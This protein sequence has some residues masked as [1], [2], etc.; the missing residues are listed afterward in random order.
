MSRT[1]STPPVV[2]RF[3]E[4]S[5]A[6]SADFP[7]KSVNPTRRMLKHNDAFL[8]CNAHGD[9]VLG[10]ANEEGYY[11]DG[12]RF[13]SRFSLKID[14][15]IPLLLG[16]HVKDQ[17]DAL[18]VTLTNGAQGVVLQGNEVQISKSI[19]LLESSC[20][21]TIQCENFSG[22]NA[23]FQFAIDFDADYADIY[24]IRGMPR[25]S[26]GTMQQSN[27]TS[28]S[29]ELAYVGLD[30]ERR[31]T[32]I[33]FD[34]SPQSV[35]ASTSEYMIKLEARE[36]FTMHAV[37]TCGRS[38]REQCLTL[39]RVEAEERLSS[40]R[41]RQLSDSVTVHSSNGQFNE[42]FDRSLADV[43]MM[44]SDLP[45]GP[46]PYA[47]IPWFNTPF[48]RDGIV[49]SLECLWMRPALARGVL[50]YL[51]E[52]QAT[53]IIPEE[54]A[55]PGKILHEIRRGEMAALKEMPFG[56]YYGS[57]DATPL[58]VMLAGAYY[59]RTADLDFIRALW[60]AVRSAIAWMKTYGDTD[61]DGFIEYKR[62]APNGL[63]HQAWKDSDDAI[64]HADGSPAQGALAVCEVQ[65]Y[66]YGA[67]RAGAV[68]AERLGH[69]ADCEDLT[70]RAE[71]LYER[72]NQSFWSEELQTYGL[73]L[74]G[75]KKLC[76]VK[77][78]NAGQCLFS[79]VA[80]PSRA[81]AIANGLFAPDCYSGWG[82][83]TL[84][85]NSARFNP[86]SYHN[87]SV[88]PHDNGLI[89]LGLS[90]YGLTDYVCQL[91]EDIF[92]SVTYF[93]RYRL[94]ELFC[95]FEREKGVAPV[96]YPVACAPQ[97]WSA[98]S[99]FL[100]IQACLGLQIDGIS[101]EV[102]LTRP[103]LPGSLRDIQIHN[104]TV[105]GVVLNFEVSG[106]GS[107]TNIKT[108]GDLKGCSLRLR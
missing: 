43:N 4:D 5:S 93:D 18:V 68:L 29:V 22:G 14:D 61:G 56:R 82:I 11:F 62:Q 80:P 55:E 65:G 71:S 79:G 3:E 89:A 44:T 28:S 23:E 16:S 58:F 36:T 17:N 74:D 88:W 15:E 73:A 41:Q 49:T 101:R 54:D 30:Q 19:F 107:N 94:P 2:P 108:A 70:Q 45:T 92:A 6:P 38:G 7:M 34:P 106:S 25:V 104:L 77:S 47:G 59:E 97:S 86:M 102:S 8:L 12:T 51:A 103:M 48:G 85:S 99:I 100:L 40:D 105:G 20:Y 91:F 63:I 21:V 75:D 31:F 26:H 90:R 52:T 27:V 87:G 96:L 42:W 13:L 1:E 9:I 84:S 72:F 66:A 83:R 60:P 50:S 78:S 67:L 69:F 39:S 32:H 98:A 95:G 33:E 37:V 76:A 64:F 46:Y 53:E 24:E 35:S 10:E 57:V 81:L